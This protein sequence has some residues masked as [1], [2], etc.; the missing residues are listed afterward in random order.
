[1][2]DEADKLAPKMMRR[3]PRSQNIKQPMILVEDKRTW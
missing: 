1:M 2:A 3:R